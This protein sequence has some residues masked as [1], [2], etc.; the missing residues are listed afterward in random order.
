M[1]RPDATRGDEQAMTADER[2]H[3]DESDERYTV[4]ELFGIKLQVSNARVAEVL[5]MDAKE[6]L[7]GASRDL[8]S[9]QAEQELRAETA[10]AV[11]DVV[12]GVPN[13]QDDRD[14]AY[15]REFRARATSVGR[16]LGF[17]AGPDGMWRSPGEATI[18]TRA[19]E[20][21]V[22]LLA[23]VH[24]VSELRGRLERSDDSSSSVL[25]IAD[26]SESVDALRSAI[27]QAH[28]HGCIRVVRMSLLEELGRMAAAGAL[29]HDEALSL[30][31]P[32]ASADVE[33]LAALLR[34]RAGGAGE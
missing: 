18:L 25:F 3:A 23:A 34:R 33:A 1:S 20:R 16:T 27:G 21:P 9:P 19:I 2:E 26:G 17:D 15:R 30:L 12:V 7:A 13:E 29:G 22:S 31:W 32:P 4:L 11:P 28:A 8:S 6:V 5:T 10:Q 14:A 24:F